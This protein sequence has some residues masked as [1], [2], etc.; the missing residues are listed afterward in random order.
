MH[1]GFAALSIASLSVWAW[2][3]RNN[4]D[5]V[6][7]VLGLLLTFHAAIAVSLAIA[8]DQLFGLVSHSTLTVACIALFFT[9]S[10]WCGVI[11]SEGS[12]D[13]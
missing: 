13:A 2:P 5:T 11:E 10:S 7:V 3:K 6:T 1:Y 12:E 8:R 9:K 4:P